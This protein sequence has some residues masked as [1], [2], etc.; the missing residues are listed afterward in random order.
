MSQASRTQARADAGRVVNSYNEWDPLE[1]VIVGVLDGSAYL[2]WEIA[3]K[4]VKPTEHVRA[5]RI[6]HTHQGG[7]ALTPESYALAQQ[8]LDTFVHILE[9]EGVKVVRPEPFDHSRPF[10]T[11][12]WTSPGGNCQAN[13]RDVLIVVG[14]EI[15]EAPMSWKSRYFEFFAYRD[16][17]VDY[18]KRGARWTAAPK[19]RLDDRSFDKDYKHGEYVITEF[20]PLF[21]AADM[22]RCG[23]DIFIQRSH[24]T[25]ELG[26]EWLQRHLGDDYRLHMVEF[27]DYRALHIDATFVPLAP[28]KI[29]INPDRPLKAMPEVLA[30]SGWELLTPPRSTFPKDDPGYLS[31]LWLSMNVLSLDE[32]RVIVE[33][34]E[35]PMIEALKSW[36]FKPI[37]V[38]FRENYRFGGSFHC[39]TVDIRRR[40]GLQSY[41]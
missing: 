31:F 36:G 20:E 39:A 38:H 18:F 30:K 15:I 16:L 4:A 35:E 8:Q 24:V 5:A 34:S 7:Q 26:V 10:G 22:A 32:K 3:L 12:E 6:F 41:F 25:N 37:P 14:D 29:M 21:D 1:E 13:P 27:D 17:V 2:P 28:G 9:A 19:P 11:P 33:A 40:G 23:R